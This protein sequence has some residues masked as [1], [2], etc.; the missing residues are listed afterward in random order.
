MTKSTISSSLAEKREMFIKLQKE[1]EVIK[2]DRMT[3]HERK[4]KIPVS[5]IQEGT[6]MPV[7]NREYDPEET[8]SPGPALGYIIKGRVK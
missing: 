5:Y 8:R 1:K 3:P 4:G 6:L 2:N 7:I